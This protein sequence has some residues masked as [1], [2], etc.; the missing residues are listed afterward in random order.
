MDY[1]KCQLIGMRHLLRGLLQLE[2]FVGAEIAFVVGRSGARENRFAQV[3]IVIAHS[4]SCVVA[5][6]ARSI[7]SAGRLAWRETACQRPSRLTQTSVSRN[8]PADSLLSP[9]SCWW[10]RLFTTAISP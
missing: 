8:S 1:L 5:A 10:K 7:I 9:A 3:L 6:L 2:Q 4:A